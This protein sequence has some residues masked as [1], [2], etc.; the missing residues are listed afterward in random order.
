MFSCF[1]L[2]KALRYCP[3]SYLVLKL[4]KKA[5]VGIFFFYHIQNSWIFTIRVGISGV[6]CNLSLMNAHV[7]VYGDSLAPP[8][9]PNMEMY[10]Y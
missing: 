10:G 8:S 6:D 4:L 1:V 2:L 5:F 3:N 7:S 9:V